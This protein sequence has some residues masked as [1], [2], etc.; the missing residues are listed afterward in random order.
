[1]FASVIK[2]CILSIMIVLIIHLILVNYKKELESSSFPSTN[3][4]LSQRKTHFKLVKSKEFCQESEKS[5]PIID[6]EIEVETDMGDFNNEEPNQEP[7][8]KQ[9]DLYDFIYDDKNTDAQLDVLFSEKNN[10]GDNAL[11]PGCDV[12]CD[13]QPIAGDSK[14]FCTN[15]IDE[16][17]Q[18]RRMTLESETGKDF[19]EAGKH[20]ILFEYKEELKDTNVVGVNEVDG[21]ESFGSSFMTL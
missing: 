16:F 9:F 10:L 17:L 12:L 18:K 8:E 21:F 19:T 15:E 3:I 2:N 11:K 4:N 14:N 7:N 5:Q 1:M 6:A 20:P 13:A